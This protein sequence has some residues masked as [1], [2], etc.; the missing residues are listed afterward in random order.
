MNVD[1][2]NQTVYTGRSSVASGIKVEAML[3]LGNAE[4][5]SRSV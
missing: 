1:I 4:I 5:S 2:Q 3:S